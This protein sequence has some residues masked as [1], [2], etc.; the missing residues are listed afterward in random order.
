MKN[1]ITI[2]TVRVSFALF[3]SCLL[4]L[5][6]TGASH[7][8]DMKD[9]DIHGFLSQG[10]LK[11]DHNNFMA[12]TEDGT[13]QFNEFGLNFT[14]GLSDRLS[15][16]LQFFG[17]D[18]GAVGN[19]EIRVDLAYL[20]YRWKD[21]AGARAGITR[22]V[23]GL[24]NEIREIDM[25][26]T[27]IFLPQS[28]Y[29]DVYRD[30]NISVTGLDFYGYVPVGR[31]GEFSYEFQYGI[32]PFKNGDGVSQSIENANFSG[33]LK[34][35]SLDSDSA[36]AYA[37]TW[38]PPLEGLK[39]RYSGFEVNDLLAKGRT[40]YTVLP[41]DVNNDGVISPGETVPADKFSVDFR[42]VRFNVASCEYSIGDLVLAGEYMEMD[43]RR[44]VTLGVPRKY[45]FP[46]QGWY[47]SGTY[48]FNSF[49][50]MGLS[51]SEFYPNANDKDGKT[52]A[53]SGK[54]NF[55]GWQKTYSVS[56]RFNLNRFW[57]VK[58]ETSYN[59]GFG[60]VQPVYNNP[61]EIEPYWW[62]FA[63]KATVRF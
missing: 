47:V 49:F 12:Q 61:A 8:F 17:R 40:P 3:L 7:A 9:V 1:S 51:Y 19:D 56:A 24:Y 57:L 46:Y 59:D 16:G 53:A 42:L 33:S 18:M 34:V 36:Y 22:M 28:V 39:L 43:L 63:A 31:L 11:T 29:V 35:D 62:L 32:L 20:D 14:T 26:R 10:Y 58:L 54:K 50:G 27:P 23:Y 25:L 6:E 48:G 21:W 2:K 37:L 4:Y 13:F 15:A 55:Q 5:A 30:S 44:T 52:L 38:E 41:A 60:A 45:N